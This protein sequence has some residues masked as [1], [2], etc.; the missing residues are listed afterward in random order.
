[1]CGGVP[2]DIDETGHKSKSAERQSVV[3]PNKR[4]TSGEDGTHKKQ[5]LNEFEEDRNQTREKNE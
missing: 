1:M 5:F 3:T 2:A 4:A